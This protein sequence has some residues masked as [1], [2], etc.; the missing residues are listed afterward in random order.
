MSAAITDIQAQQIGRLHTARPSFFGI[1]RGELLKISRLKLTWIMLGILTLGI[2]AMHVLMSVGR[3]VTTDLKTDP[4]TVLGQDMRFSIEVLRI[5]GGMLFLILTAYI[6][7]LEFQYGT[8]RIVLSRGVGRVQLLLGK[9][10]AMVVFSLVVIVCGLLLNMLTAIIL[11]GITA[12]NFDSLKAINATFW[13][14]SGLELLYLLINTGVTILLATA[15][16]VLGRSL[17]FGLSLALIWFPMDNM[18]TYILYIMSA[19]THNAFW[20]NV[21]VYL[22]GPNLNVMGGMFIN[23]KANIGAPPLAPVDLAHTL[24]IVLAYAVAFTIVAITVTWKRDVKE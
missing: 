4:L 17:A 6:I 8:I 13:S 15:M 20:A 19:I 12:G 3:D 24:W 2:I 7:G 9:L 18:G 11:I 10:A 16:A 23:S 14:N 22:L 21:S 5:F 1:V